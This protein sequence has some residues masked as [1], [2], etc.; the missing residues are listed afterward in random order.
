MILRGNF[1]TDNKLRK[2]MLHRY[3]GLR[4]NYRY[5]IGAFTPHIIDRCAY[6]DR[7]GYFCSIGYRTVV[8]VVCPYRCFIR[9]EIYRTGLRPAV[10]L[11]GRLVVLGIITRIG[12]SPSGCLV[13]EQS[14][15]ITRRPVCFGS[16][17][18]SC[19]RTYGR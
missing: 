5:L 13:H 16:E 15:S 4:F 2:R 9:K 11:S 14:Q 18:C 8:R 19:F 12:I 17:T 10:C 7:D 6:V 1:Q 3:S